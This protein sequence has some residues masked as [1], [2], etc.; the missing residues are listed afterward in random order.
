MINSVI[1]LGS[2]CL[3]FYSMV[4]S[5]SVWFP[6]LLAEGK[7]PSLQQQ[8]NCEVIDDGVPWIKL[9]QLARKRCIHHH[10]FNTHGEELIITPNELSFPEWGDPTIKFAC[11]VDVVERA[12]EYIRYTLEQIPFRQMFCVNGVVFG[13]SVVLAQSEA[14]HQD[15]LMQRQVSALLGQYLFRNNV[16]DMSLWEI[17]TKEAL[18]IWKSSRRPFPFEEVGSLPAQAIDGYQHDFSQV[19]IVGANLPADWVNYMVQEYHNAWFFLS[20]KD[21]IKTGFRFAKVRP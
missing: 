1:H 14:V 4:R 3:T 2:A 20:A 13:A 12:E 17:S 7:E 6:F 8:S 15:E 10:G 9:L 21:S 18:S 11:M 5:L 16:I 19:T